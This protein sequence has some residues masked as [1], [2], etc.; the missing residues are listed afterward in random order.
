MKNNSKSPLKKV[1]YGHRITLGFG[2]LFGFI[3]LLHTTN[4]NDFSSKLKLNIEPKQVLK[5]LNLDKDKIINQ[6]INENKTD[7][8]FATVCDDTTITVT[9]DTDSTYSL[10]WVSASN[11]SAKDERY[12]ERKLAKHIQHKA[13]QEMKSLLII[14]KS[15]LSSYTKKLS[16]KKAELEGFN[17]AHNL[18]GTETPLTTIAKKLKIIDD[19]INETTLKLRFQES[20]DKG[21]TQQATTL[22]QLI[23]QLLNEKKATIKPLLQDSEIHIKVAKKD[24]ILLEIKSLE[25]LMVKA[26]ADIKL[27][28]DKA[29]EVKAIHT[30]QT[31]N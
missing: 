19:K 7:Y 28:E 8:C 12:F 15:D 25:A 26:R 6:Y 24:N 27:I 16:V 31:G 17:R 18:T 1:K 22:R 13:N 9:K 5:T 21:Q 14:S 29:V 23:S 4:K 30:I 11:R 10:D 20:I 3:A 2:V